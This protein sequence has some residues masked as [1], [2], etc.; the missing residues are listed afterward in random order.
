MKKIL[1]NKLYM[2]TLISDN[3]SN[4][5]DILFYLAL[6][7][8]V[9]QIP[10][11]K[12]AVAL[13]G[14]SEMLPV[15][16]GSFLGYLADR[17]PKKVFGIL[18]TQFFRVL[19]YMVL[20]L[21]L[22]FS[23]QL[24]IVIVAILVNLVSDMSGFFENALFR[25]LSLRLVSDEDRPQAMGLSASISATSRIVFNSAGAIL[26]T[27]F[28]YQEVAFINAGTFLLAALIMLSIKKALEALFLEKPLQLPKTSS[29]ENQKPSFIHSFK[30]GLK[31]LFA[32]PALKESMIIAPLLNAVGVGVP[33]LYLLILNDHPK[34]ILISQSA[35][36]AGL[37]IAMSLGT[38]VGGL[39]VDILFKKMPLKRIF[40]LGIVLSLLIYL[41]M[42][43]Q[44]TLLILL[45]LFGISVGSGALNPR[46]SA[47]VYNHVAE[48]SLGIVFNGMVTY[49]SLGMVVFQLILSGLIV[50]LPVNLIL[51]ILMSLCLFLFIYTMT[52]KSVE[53]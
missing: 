21:L 8:Y 18:A 40:L 27:W 46:I 1:T 33:M 49:F 35:S 51:W 2:T 17:Y 20:G 43:F 29:D 39:A 36:I 23:P 41:A 3:L 48:E 25:P 26:L 15:M 14:I 7:S 10:E 44:Q 47:L 45:C 34:S 28:T 53:V 31:E 13:I 11:T 16:L 4:F 52:I 50:V 32:I 5:G 37:S 24:W 22:G 30:Q 19:L 6:M 42:L 12:L 9:L 38:I